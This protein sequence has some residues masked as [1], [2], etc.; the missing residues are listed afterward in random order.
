MCLINCFKEVRNITSI[1]PEAGY[2]VTLVM[3]SHSRVQIIV[4]VSPPDYIG[5]I[6]IEPLRDSGGGSNSK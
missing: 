2:P 5:G 1:F 6:H 4:V 3:L